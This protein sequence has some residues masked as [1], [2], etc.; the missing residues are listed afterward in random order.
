MK[1]FKDIVNY[2]KNKGLQVYCLLL[3]EKYE[4]LPDEDKE[5]LKAYIN[6]GILDLK[7][8]KIKNPNNS[9]EELEGI[10]FT[11]SLD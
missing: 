7:C 5:N 3:K 11:A 6:T 10:L 8:V 2:D 4:K 9:E 1:V